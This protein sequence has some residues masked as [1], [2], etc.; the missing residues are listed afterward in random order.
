M[1]SFIFPHDL[2][3]ISVCRWR[4]MIFSE[5]TWI[6]LYKETSTT[7]KTILR[8]IYLFLQSFFSSTTCTVSDCLLIDSTKVD[9]VISWNF[10]QWHPHEFNNT[11]GTHCLFKL[12]LKAF[13]FFFYCFNSTYIKIIHSQIYVICLKR[14]FCL[15]SWFTTILSCW[16]CK[17]KGLRTQQVNDT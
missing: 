15:I 6:N 4:I 12:F 8:S 1:L 5:W 17:Y 2:S 9:L 11:K 16:T 13:Q 10:N 14:H 3:F 7:H